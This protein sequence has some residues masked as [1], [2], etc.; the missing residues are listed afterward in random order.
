MQRTTARS[1]VLTKH[2]EYVSDGSRRSYGKPRLSRNTG[3]R[4]ELRDYLR[5]VRAQW[6]FIAVCVLVS[7]A[8]AV[9]FTVRATPIYSASVKLIVNARAA[10]GDPTTAYQGNL[11]SQQLVK[12]YADLLTGRT[13]AQAVATDLDLDISA[14]QIMGALHAVGPRDYLYKTSLLEGIWARFSWTL[15]F[16]EY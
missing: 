8:S 7:T 15:V 12:S 13:M 9:L 14:Q 11:L 2:Q 6:L 16:I 3:V 4:V 10:A 5:L 1:Y